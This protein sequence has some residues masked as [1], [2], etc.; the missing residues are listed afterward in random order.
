MKAKEIHYDQFTLR[1]KAQ[2]FFESSQLFATQNC[3]L[4]KKAREFVSKT[5]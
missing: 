5:A 1:M 3:A 2:H 4:F